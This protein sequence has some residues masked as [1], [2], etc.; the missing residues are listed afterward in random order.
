MARCISRAARIAAGDYLHGLYD[1]FE[2]LDS[3]NADYEI[4]PDTGEIKIINEQ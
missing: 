1:E 3:I 2:I 4:N